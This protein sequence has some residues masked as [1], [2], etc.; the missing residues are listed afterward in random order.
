MPDALKDGQPL[1]YPRGKINRAATPFTTASGK[2]SG[3][4]AVEDMF[5]LATEQPSHW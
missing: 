5:E 4:F 3:A 1:P 2:P